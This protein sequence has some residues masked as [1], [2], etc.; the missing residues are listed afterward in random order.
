MSDRMRP[1][2]FEKI[3][4]W[5]TREVKEKESIFGIHKNKFYKNESGKSI[6]VFGEKLSSP[7]GPAAGPNTQLTQNIVS[8]YLTGSRFIELKTV[9]VIDG[10]DLPV[11]KPCIH[12]QD[13]GYNVEWSTELKVSDAFN[14]YIKAWFLLHI[15]MRELNLSKQRDFMFNMSVG[16][17]LNGIKSPKIDNYI[18]GMRNASNTKVWNECK[19]VIT[20]NMNLFD[21][22]NEKDLEKISPV[23]CSSIT[24][25]TL[26][27]CPPEEIEKI[28]N[29]LLRE[30]K[31]NT[32]I[33]MNPTLLGEKFVRNT[34][35][36]M[37]YVYITLNEDHFKNDLQYGDAVAMLQRLKDAARKMNLEIGVKLTNTLPVKIQNSELPGE[38]MYMSGR[39]LF[40]LTISLASKLAK[41]FEGDLQISYSG[42]ADFF[43]V[44]KILA[45]GI[46]PVTFATTILKPGGY[47]RITQMAQKLEKKL[48]GAF[49][50]I[51]TDMLSKLLLEALNDKHYL[52]NSR[53]VESKKLS[54]ELP[55]YDCAAA[56]CSIGCPINQQIPEYIALAGKK[57]YYEAFSIIAKDNAS[58]AITAAIC[59]HNCQFKC[60]RLDYDSSILIRDMKKV[61]V[62]NAEK[63]YIENIKPADIKS[64]KKVVVI[65][66]GPAGLSTALFLRRNGMDVTV[67][68]QKE[69]S[70][71]A[72]RY[73]IPDF[74]IPY[75]MIDQDFELIKKQGVKFKFGI[76]E[77][78]NIDELKEKYDYIILAI[79]AWK[80]GRVP[81]KEGSEKAV[82]AIAFLERYKSEKENIN[83]GNQVCVIGGGNV[84]MD[85]ARAAKRIA[86][87]ENVSVVYR[88]TRE[89]MPADSEELD[90]AVSE[91][92]VFRE[93]LAPMGIRENKLICQEMTLGERDASGR[94]SPVPSGKEVILDVDTVI[95]AVGEKVNSDLLKRNAIELDSKGFPKLNTACES[96][97]SNVYIP[98]DAKKGPATIVKAIADGK[99]VAKDILSKEGLNNDFEKKVIPIDEKEIYSRKGVLRDSE[100]C[101]EESER[102]LSCSNICE[103]CVDVCPNRA[104]AVINVE[105]GFSSSHQII[106]LDGMCNE[107]GNCGIFCPYKGNPYKD[108]VTVFWNENDFENSKNKGFYII[109]IKK[110]ICKVRREDDKVVMYTIGEKDIVS[111]EMEYIIRSCIDKYSYML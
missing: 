1:I 12:A 4:L 13:E 40:S 30:K 77:D 10:E 37:G 66:A 100:S 111:K 11:A 88:R 109:D 65:G 51:D 74:R 28:S 90:L 47:E 85:A 89:Y 24:V 2:S 63:K 52:K 84:A 95:A 106:H 60:T 56:P 71:G 8:A 61:V 79:G 29:Y 14:E 80:P 34:L 83:L 5:I 64:N 82:N 41:E 104:N 110:S 48:K 38:E 67:M 102:C 54:I 103:L 23:I 42:G 26:H 20:S 59:N 68:E 46:Q 6:E 76:N 45:V 96:S 16:Y 33:K 17:D 50:Q 53:T 94:R 93:L 108:K 55:I 92:V 49:S 32:F 98:G 105:G 7:L 58:P 78:F 18:E 31:L 101:E 15:L 21:N 36:T 72:V 75:E 39:S 81:L 69:K 99:A 87:V 22:F 86:G 73:A 62:L 44:D 107:C 3:L 57:K 97:I 91:G 27:G 25:S 19:K 35:N 70:Y 43:N 9:Q